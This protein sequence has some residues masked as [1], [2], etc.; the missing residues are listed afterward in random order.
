MLL[1]CGQTQNIRQIHPTKLTQ[2]S[3]RRYS[4]KK[5]VLRNFA[6][7]TGKQLCQ[8]IFFNKISLLKKRP[9]HGWFPV[10]FAKFLR[11]PF[12]QNTFGRLFVLTVRS[13]IHLCF[14]IYFISEIFLTQNRCHWIIQHK[15]T[16]S[17]KHL[18]VENQVHKEETIK[19]SKLI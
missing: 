14:Q 9:W 13:Y 10:N 1:I 8:S 11:T 3:H 15:K 18:L 16:C 17:N 2:N 6:K 12:S 5:G 19:V 7:F 4:V